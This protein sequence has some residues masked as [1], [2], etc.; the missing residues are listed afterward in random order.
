MTITMLM[1]AAL[2]QAAPVTTPQARD[3][4]DTALP[5]KRQTRDDAAPNI[6]PMDRLSTRVENRIDARIQ[7]RLA[8]SQPNVTGAYEAATDQSRR[9]R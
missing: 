7:N 2:L 9:R 6:A 8:R 3:D 1:V 4:A 5:G